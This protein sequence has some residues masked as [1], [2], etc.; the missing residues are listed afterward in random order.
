VS[1]EYVLDANVLFGAFISGKDVYRL[2]FSGHTIYLPDYAFAEI[3][4][5]K[6]RILKKTKLSEH[7]FQG[8]VLT[9][10][11]DVTVVPSLVLS[12]ASLRQAYE[13]CKDL[14]EKDTVYVATAIELKAVLVTS[15]K[16]LH[17]GLKERDFDGVALLG[18]IV[19]GLLATD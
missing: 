6:S 4:K 17:D 16:T 15:D 11:G 2:L 14:D 13:F 3:E 9:L 7:D 18:E 1:Q 10:L 12:P 5:Y 19:E 8:F